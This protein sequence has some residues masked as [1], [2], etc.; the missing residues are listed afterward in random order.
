MTNETAAAVA[1]VVTGGAASNASITNTSFSQISTISNRVA[2]RLVRS[3]PPSQSQS[4]SEKGMASGNENP[5]WN[6]WG[7]TTGNFTRQDYSF[8]KFKVNIMS[9]IIG[10][11]YTF[12]QKLVAGLSASFDNGDGAMNGVFTSSY[13]SLISPYIGIQLTPEWVVDFS[14]GV[15]SG[16]LTFPGNSGI[17]STRW[18]AGTN[19]TYS[20][21]WDVIQLSGKI[22]YLYGEESSGNS[23]TNGFFNPR[24]RNQLGRI[25]AEAQAGYWMESIMPY[26]GVAYSN[27]I[28]RESNGPA[29]PIGKDTLTWIVGLNIFSLKDRLT[30]GIAYNRDEGRAYQDNGFFMANINYN[31]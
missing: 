30:G 9:A 8:T 3:A 7:N 31:F 26:V 22:G 13:G 16:K 4:S 20:H 12:S 28:Y 15:G 14:V 17:K 29:N 27:D 1:R 18:F 21:W 10:G 24:V 11:D 25:N 5:K 2:S 19:L 6:V 23:S